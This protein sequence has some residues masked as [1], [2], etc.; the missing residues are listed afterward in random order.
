MTTRRPR[1]TLA[2]ATVSESDGVRYLHLG[3]PWVQGAMRIA[4]P[5]TIELEYVQRLMA[6]LLLRPADAPAGHAVQLGLGAATVTKFCHKKLR[7]RCTVVEINPAVI[8]VCRAW[9]RLPPDDARLAVVEADAGGWVADPAHAG[10][11]D[12]LCV[13]LYDHE[14]AAPVLDDEAFYR[15]CHAVL[16][17]G[18]V[19]SVN[20]FGR[21]VS[22]GRSA[23]RIAA[24]FGEGQ[25]AMLKPTK[26]GNTIVLA[27]KGGAL[28][29]R[30]ELAR[31]ATAIEAR[32]DLPARKWVKLLQNLPDR[33]ATAA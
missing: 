13:D 14:A 30:E 23:A 31:R 15:A 18:G 16:A 24:V 8:G 9:F 10:T 7:W 21:D 28:P 5:Q 25:V 6:W 3:T 4:K 29:P 1:P 33:S 20:L 19:M 32:V 17:D 2:P 11:A 12:A 27:W 26:E 22:F